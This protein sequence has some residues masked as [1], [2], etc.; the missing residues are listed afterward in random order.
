MSTLRS[1]IGRAWMPLSIVAVLAIVGLALAGTTAALAQDDEAPAPTPAVAPDRPDE[2]PVADIVD[3]PAPDDAQDRDVEEPA[4][5]EEPDGAPEPNLIAPAP[6][7][8]QHQGV[9]EPAPVGEEEGAAEPNLI[10]PASTGS[11]D[12]LAWWVY[13]LIAGGAAIVIAAGALTWRFR[14]R[15]A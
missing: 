3:E 6:D 9:V 13:A 10:G 7:E 2:V 15:K 8:A 4:P 12:G 5:A 1:A 11:D 14:S